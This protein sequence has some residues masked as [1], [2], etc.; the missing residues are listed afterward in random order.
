METGLNGNSSGAGNINPAPGGFPA[1]PNLD[2]MAERAYLNGSFV[3]PGQPD[4]ADAY[5]VPTAAQPY[6]MPA[7]PVYPPAAQM[8]RQTP[9]R[10]A[11]PD[12]PAAP[13]AL[14]CYGKSSEIYLN[15]LTEFINDEYGDYL[16]YTAMANKAP[17]QNARR[18]FRSMARTE[19]SHSKNFGAAYF[20]ISGK[21][22]T[23][24]RA[25]AGSVQIPAYDQALRQRFMAE[26]RDAAKYMAFA[27]STNDRCLKKLAM[28]TSADER[29]HAQHILELIQTMG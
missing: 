12:P 16:F 29:Q 5:A 4:P 3:L 20:L 17:T 18:I 2:A 22:Y 21:R 25:Q 19:L 11:P 8:P 9:A 7:Q 14:D 26:T 15:Q 10:M 24:A 28:D 6:A 27:N 13:Q 23:P 1:A